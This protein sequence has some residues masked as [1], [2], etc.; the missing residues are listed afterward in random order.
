MPTTG[1]VSGATGVISVVLLSA[2]VVLGVLLDRC[3]WLAARR[4]RAPR[5]R[6]DSAAAIRAGAASA[7]PRAIRGLVT[8]CPAM[9]PGSGESTDAWA[10]FLTDLKTGA[11][12]ARCWVSPTE[13]RV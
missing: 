11:W 12:P 5:S 6:A 7:R 10:D 13:P 9:T 4:R 8:D 1:T 2:V 3:G